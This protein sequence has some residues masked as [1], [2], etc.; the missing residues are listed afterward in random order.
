M[1]YLR[2]L[3]LVGMAAACVAHSAVPFIILFWTALSFDLLSR[4]IYLVYCIGFCAVTDCVPLLNCSGVPLA[5]TRHC[6][7]WLY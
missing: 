7:A 3:A 6:A 1:L 4:Y 5:R 2:V